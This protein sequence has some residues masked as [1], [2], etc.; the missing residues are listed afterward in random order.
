[1]QRDPNWHISLALQGSLA[2]F[3][4]PEADLSIL[5]AGLSLS[6][7]WPDPLLLP[8]LSQDL[9]FLAFSKEFLRGNEVQSSKFKKSSTGNA[10]NSRGLGSTPRAC[11]RWQFRSTA[12]KSWVPFEVGSR[13][14]L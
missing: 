13:F 8:G 11:G 2:N 14:E 1:M 12:G 5:L 7:V 3:H 10:P 9:L 6:I 4:H